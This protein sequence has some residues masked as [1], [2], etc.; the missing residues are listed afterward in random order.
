MGHAS[1]RAAMIYQHATAERDRALA[2][3]LS[4]LATPIGPVSNAPNLHLV[5]TD[6][7]NSGRQETP[8]D[9]GGCAMDRLRGIRSTLLRT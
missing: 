4:Q 9:G 3:A 1:P 6:E 7:R 8:G 5:A 2:D